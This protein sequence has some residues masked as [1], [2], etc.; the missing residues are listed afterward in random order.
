M[1]KEI[2]PPIIETE[3]L[4]LRPRVITDAAD[5]FEFASDP[6]VT[7]YVNFDTNTSI[8]ET[9]QFLETCIKRYEAKELYDYAFVLKETGK[10]IGGG[11]AFNIDRFPHRCEIGYV[12]NRKYWGQGFVPEAMKAVIDY[13]FRNR[14]VHRIE[15]YHYIGN[16]KSGRVMQKIGMTYEGT[17][18]DRFFVKGKYVS[19]KCYAIINPYDTTQ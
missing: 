8:E 7:K 12:L 3:R 2:F 6:E 5:I 17:Q 4:I 15:S 11:G 18:I 1:T 16:E 14:L 19:A 9:V 13:L 10:V